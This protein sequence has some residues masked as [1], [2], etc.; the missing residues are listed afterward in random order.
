VINEILIPAFVPDLQGRLRTYSAGGVSNVEPG[1]SEFQR[2]IVFVHLQPVY[3]GRLW[4]RVD[5]NEE[6]KQVVESL[7]NKFAYLTHE[8]CDLFSSDAFE[9]Y[10]PKVFQ[11]KATEVLGISDRRARQSAKIELLLSVLSWTK[12]NENVALQEWSTSAA[13]PIELLRAIKAK[14]AEE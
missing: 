2:L 3:Q 14:L 13:E 11:E 10:Y 8:T 5:S 7:H 12:A 9:R 1:I 4:V 6:G